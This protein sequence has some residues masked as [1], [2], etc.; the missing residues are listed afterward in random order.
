M[1]YATRNRLITQ[2]GYASYEAYLSGPLW[3]DIRSRVLKSSGG[4][5]L[6]CRRAATQV[7]HVLYDLPTLLGHSFDGL[8]P[9]CGGC[10]RHAEITRAGRKR[11]FAEAITQLRLM[12]RKARS[13]KLHRRKC[14]SCWRKP[15]ARS[16]YCSLHA[17]AHRP[18]VA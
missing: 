17:R 16:L 13:G 18:T 15:T 9:L 5:C 8:V 11:T 4:L 6:V 12:G 1:S 2:L 10:H 7:H 14:P 3:A